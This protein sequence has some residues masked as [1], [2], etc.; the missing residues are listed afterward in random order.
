MEH[1]FYGA[2][3]SKLYII[4]SQAFS[5]E[6]A[7]G[8]QPLRYSSSA[9]SIRKNLWRLDHLSASK[10]LA[11]KTSKR[12][13]LLITQAVWKFWL[14]KTAP[15][16]SLTM[17]TM[18]RQP[19]QSAVCGKRN[20]KRAKVS[21]LLGATGS[22]WK[23]PQRLRPPLNQHHK[24]TVILTADDPNYENHSSHCG[25]ASLHLLSGGK[26]SRPRKMHQR[27]SPVDR[28]RGCRHSNGKEQMLTKS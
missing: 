9:V 13:E 14:R 21:L 1:D 7:G 6:A 12:K 19:K 10:V 20:T 11:S 5:F 25:I 18:A 28:P 23:P 2:G 4:D 22:G 3:S 17:L 8:L 27:S 24:L 15:R 26:N 16:S